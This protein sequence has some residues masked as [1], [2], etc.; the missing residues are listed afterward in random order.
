MAALPPLT[1]DPY[2]NRS[3]IISSQARGAIAVS[4]SDSTDLATPAKALFIGSAGNVTILP[5]N[6]TDDTQT[7]QFAN[8]PVGYMPVQIRRVMNTGTSASGIVALTDG[9]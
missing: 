3:T 1:N 4:P 6:A 8:H 9:T 7:I 5:I 2:A